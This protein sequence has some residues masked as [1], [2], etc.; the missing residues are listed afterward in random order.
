MARGEVCPLCRF[1]RIHSD[2][3]LMELTSQR[4]IMGH[5]TLWF[6]TEIQHAKM[7]NTNKSRPQDKVVSL[8]GTGLATLQK[9]LINNWRDHLNSLSRPL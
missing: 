6:F 4:F 9:G 7:V 1:G 2:P 8:G 5:L 3:K